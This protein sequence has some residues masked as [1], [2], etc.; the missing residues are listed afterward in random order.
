MH[1]SLQ[2]NLS[3]WRA[4]ARNDRQRRGE[5]RARS[6]CSSHGRK[7]RRGP[8]S[9]HCNGYGDANRSSTLGIG[10]FT[11]YA[12]ATRSSP[13]DRD[14]GRRSPNEHAARKRRSSLRRLPLWIPAPSR[15]G[16]SLRAS[17]PSIASRGSTSIPTPALPHPEHLEHRHDAGQQP[18]RCRGRHGDDRAVRAWCFPARSAGSRALGSA[19]SSSSRSTPRRCCNRSRQRRRPSVGRS[20]FRPIQSRWR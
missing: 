4:D 19:S 6:R 20:A 2:R 8:K 7:F 5:R 16:A 14:A 18:R 13:A 3:V 12:R 9:R 10:Q 15:I 1:A 17:S 11:G